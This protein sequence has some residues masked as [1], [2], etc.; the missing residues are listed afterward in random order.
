MKSKFI[1]SLKVGD[2]LVNEPFLLQNVV[3]RTTKDGRPYL[4]YTLRDNSGQ[5]GG[6]F[7]DVPD[8]VRAWVKP[9]LVAMV[10]GKAHNYKE[11]LQITATDINVVTA[12]DLTDFL[13]SSQRS[14]EEMISELYE[15]ISNLAEP[16]QRLA[17]SLLLTEDFLPQFVNSPAARG[18]HHAF[19]GGL[20]EHS[21]SM[22]KLAQTLSAHYPYVN[23][24]LLVTGA[25]VHDMGKTAEY[26]IEDSFSVSDDG[27]LVGHIVRAVVMIEQAAADIDFPDDLL[28]QLVHLVA[29]HH[30]KQEWGSPVVPKTLEAIL[31]HQIDLLDSRVQGFFDH[32]RGDRGGD[33]WTIQDSNMF[34]TVLQRPSGFS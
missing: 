8:Y 14:R 13:P 31:L 15:C 25:L 9:G 30:G 28:R 12:P 21:L 20:L 4:L 17:S 27:K 2:E 10:S 7:W 33:K 5:V 26:M 23:Q 6:V 1:S 19:I 18:M 32:L 22:A 34:G 29:S 11:A 16:W 24:N 3:V